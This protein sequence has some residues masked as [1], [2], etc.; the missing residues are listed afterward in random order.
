MSEIGGYSGGDG[1]SSNDDDSRTGSSGGGKG[2]SAGSSSEVGGRGGSGE[3]F[4]GN[5]G[6]STGGGGS[7]GEGMGGG[8][9]GGEGVFDGGTESGKSGGVSEGIQEGKSLDTGE[10]QGGSKSVENTDKSSSETLEVDET[11]N[12]EEA[13]K[14]V[15]SYHEASIA[16]ILESN[17]KYISESDRERVIGGVD[18]LQVVAHRE[19]APT[20]RYGFHDG[21]SRISVS[22]INETQMERS[23]KHETNHFVSTNR[24]IIVPMP[25]QKGYTVYNTVGTRQSSWFH[26]VETG[27]DYNYTERGRGM[28]EGITT[29][30]T[31]QQLT[32]ISK[33]KGEEAARQGIYSMQT[34]LCTQLEEIVGKD[35][36]REA[37]Y[38]GNLQGLEQKV[39]ALAGEKEFSHFRDCLDRT[40]DQDPAVRVEAMRE[41]QDILARMSERSEQK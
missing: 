5:T 31:N 15:E 41:A 13:Q 34:E 33:E 10:V 28:N 24:E 37:Y 3:G 39:D 9:R 20:G 22:A 40:L 30:L 38:G 16:Q 2:S 25:D 27:M 21:S 26:S 29:M 23:T 8:E 12:L 32:E 11:I 7:G 36:V 19:G 1:L 35:S 4:G 17:G 14:S 18:H 6:G